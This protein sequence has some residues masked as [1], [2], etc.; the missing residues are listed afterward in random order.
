[1]KNANLILIFEG[2]NDW[3][4]NSNLST[5]KTRFKRDIATVKK[6]NPKAYILGILPLNR[7]DKKSAGAYQSKNSAGYTLKQLHD[8]EKTIYRSFKIPYVTF[9]QMGYQ[10]TK[11]A[12]AD[13]LHPK[14]S[15]HKQM[16]RA[17]AKYLAKQ[18]KPNKMSLNVTTKKQVP[19]YQ[20]LAFTSQR[21]TTKVKT[22]YQA[23]VKY[24]HFNGKTYYSIYDSQG[25]WQGYGDASQFVGAGLTDYHRYQKY[26]TVWKRGYKLYQDKSL[27]KT[28]QMSD[29]LYH[30]TLIAKGYYNAT[31]GYRYVS[32][33]DKNDRWQGYMNQDAFKL[34]KTKGG[35][36]AKKI[37]KV[38][39]TK[40]GVRRWGHLN[41]T[42]YNGTWTRGKVYTMKYMYHHFNNQHYLSLYNSRN[43]WLGYINKSAVQYVS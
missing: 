31:N 43:Q 10:L 14:A 2:T 8:A 7:W 25:R 13:G 33:Y 9:D 36:S 21:S 40:S 38:K 3:G 32:L 24:R 15:A 42:S 30:D 1:M 26:G 11:S 12:T 6:L 19:L 16:G 39:I 29:K 41:L 37:A 20:D 17:L 18:I 4:R 22:T 28:R 34:G 35:A 5:F 27:K 23:R